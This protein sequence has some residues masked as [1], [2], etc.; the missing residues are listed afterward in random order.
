MEERRL[1][2]TPCCDLSKCSKRCVE[3][4]Y[5]TSCDVL[6]A[7]REI[8]RDFLNA[9]LL[10]DELFSSIRGRFTCSVHHCS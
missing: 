2:A 9:F 10:D 1:A 3:Y 6:H 7:G 5:C 4:S 8:E